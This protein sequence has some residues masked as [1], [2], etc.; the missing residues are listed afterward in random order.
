MMV[1]DFHNCI[2]KEVRKQ[3]LE[4][5]GGAPDILV[6]CIGGGSNAIGLFNEFVEDQEVRLIG[7]EA[8]G[9]GVDTD[10]HAATLTKG[11]PGVLHGSMSY[12]LQSGDGQIIE[13]HSVSAG[14][15]YPGVG[16]EHSYLQFLN[17]FGD[18]GSVGSTNHRHQLSTPK[19]EV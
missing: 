3:A 15:D 4:R 6:A 2:G 17:S 7:V 1:R 9:D 5:W 14:L 16:P 12:L 18:E 13:P 11:S 8:A 19:K 10:R